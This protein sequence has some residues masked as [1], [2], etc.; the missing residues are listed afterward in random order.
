[1]RVLYWKGMPQLY[2]S[3]ERKWRPIGEWASVAYEGW[4]LCICL[5]TGVYCI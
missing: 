1:M 2:N 3:G 4:V 5:V